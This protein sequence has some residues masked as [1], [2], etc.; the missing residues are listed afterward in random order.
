MLDLLQATVINALGELV[1]L[2]EY[3]DPDYFWALRGGGGSA[4]GVSSL[5][6]TYFCWK[7]EQYWN[8][9]DYFGH[10]QNTS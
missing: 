7:T 4:W 5:D 10:I 1:V 9:G 6:V 2:N 3:T 8:L